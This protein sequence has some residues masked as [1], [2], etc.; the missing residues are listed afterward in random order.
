MKLWTTT[1]SL[2]R[3]QV[4][5]PRFLPMCHGQSRPKTVWVI[6]C[7]GVQ[8]P[9][10]QNVAVPAGNG[11]SQPVWLRKHGGSA[12]R[13]PPRIG[14]PVVVFRCQTDSAI[15]I[16]RAGAAIVEWDCGFG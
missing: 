5:W 15:R 6:G 10:H 2:R 12:D 7:V 16:V 8:P 4:S 9:C 11:G 3:F 13:L 14:A 1:P